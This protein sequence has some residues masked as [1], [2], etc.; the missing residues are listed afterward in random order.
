MRK[1]TRQEGNMSKIE[2]EMQ[3]IR[4]L[5]LE[6]WGRALAVD[7]SELDLDSVLLH[8][9]EAND[10]VNESIRLYAK[11]RSAQ[12]RQHGFANCTAAKH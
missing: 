2:K 4:S 5:I 7:G 10:S 1:R 8:L 6:A 11:A 12:G 3:A 9:D